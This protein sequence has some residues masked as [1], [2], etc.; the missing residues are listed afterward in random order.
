[1]NRSF[2]CKWN[3]VFG[4]WRVASK[5]VAKSKSKSSIKLKRET[6]KPLSTLLRI[7]FLVGVCVS[8]L[9]VMADTTWLGGEGNWND[10]TKWDAGVPTANDAAIIR[11]GTVTLNSTGAVADELVV[12][13]EFI[14]NGNG[15]LKVNLLSLSENGSSRFEVTGAKAS[16]AVSKF[17]YFGH[18]CLSLNQGGK[19]T[20][21]SAAIYDGASVEVMGSGSSW[22]SSNVI[23]ISTNAYITVRSGGSIT[24]DRFNMFGYT[25]DQ[26]AGVLN[27]GAPEG[28]TATAAGHVS[29][30]IEFGEN[31]GTLVLNHTDKDYVLASKIVTNNDYTGNGRINLL[32]GTTHFT[33]DL[34]G[35][36]GEVNVKSRMLNIPML[37]AVTSR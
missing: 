12:D 25:A 19:L 3:D 2:Q 32:N 8:A 26:Q 37:D 24:A 7:A 4:L 35:Y 23:S 28:E 9:P 31:G 34:S 33:G 18:G 10:A 20:S 15:Q 16:L 22:I 30:E 29:G 11:S 5:K 14:I 1:M 17:F 36:K 6:K 21:A 13:G 27:I